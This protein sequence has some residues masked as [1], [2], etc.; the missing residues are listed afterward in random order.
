LASFS[1]TAARAHLVRVTA[2]LHRAALQQSSALTT[3]G[4]GPAARKAH[5]VKGCL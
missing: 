3:E 2:P 5:R 1:P 4:A